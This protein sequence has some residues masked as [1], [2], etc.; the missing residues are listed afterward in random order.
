M[1]E[2]GG[3]GRTHD[4][5]VSARVVAA[6]P[7]PVFLAGGLHPDNVE[8]AVT[9]V[10]PYGVDVCSGLRPGRGRLDV[11]MLRNFMEQFKR[12]NQETLFSWRMVHIVWNL[13]SGSKI[14]RI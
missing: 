14:K 7:V 4:W 11:D 1:A 12:Q 8:D 9:T 6:A 3:T 13:R 10:A 2:L 5:S